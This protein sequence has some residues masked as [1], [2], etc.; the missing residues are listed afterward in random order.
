MSQT[1]LSASEFYSQVGVAV[2]A[3]S[4][5]WPIESDSGSTCTLMGAGF[6]QSRARLP[7]PDT[8][9]TEGMKK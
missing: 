8:A 1:V 3:V 4:S 6:E 2:H 5:L 7:D 9:P